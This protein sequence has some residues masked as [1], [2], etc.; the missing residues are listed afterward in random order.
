MKAILALLFFPGCYS[1]LQAGDGFY[2]SDTHRVVVYGDDPARP[3]I[4]AALLE[5]YLATRFPDNEIEVI[6][7]AR[8]ATPEPTILVEKPEVLLLL[9]GDHTTF[10]ASNELT[11]KL[12]GVLPS[13]RVTMM[14][15][16]APEFRTPDTTLLELLAF[17]NAPAEVSVVEINAAAKCVVRSENTTVRELESDLA[18]AWSQDDRSLPLPSAIAQSASAARINIE[19][20]QVRGL[21]SGKYRLTIDGWTMG[22]FWREELESG[23]DLTLLSTPMLKQADRVRA[24]MLERKESKRAEWRHAAIPQT[25]DYEIARVNL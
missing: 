7:L 18:V 4:D 10:S 1:V 20:L 14:S 15:F 11:S 21:G 12:K 25:H 9:D 23:I 6:V 16:I 17:W 19:M 5:T 2:L 22:E 8:D 24:L 13:L 3:H